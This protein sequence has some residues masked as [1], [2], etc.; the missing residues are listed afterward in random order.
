MA[1]AAAPDTSSLARYQHEQLN[2]LRENLRQAMTTGDTDAVHD[3][4][5]ASRRLHNG[6]EVMEARLGRKRVRRAQR[7]LK[8]VRKAFR[9]VRDLDVL[10]A[11]LGAAPESGSLE[12]NALAE[13]EAI[14]TSRRERAMAVAKRA[15][16]EPKLTKEL[17]SIENLICLL[18]SDAEGEPALVEE[19]LTDM[20]RQRAT[21][22]LQKDP[23]E[24]T[25]NLHETRI[26]VKQMRYCVQ[27]LTDCGALDAAELVEELTA[28]QGLLGHWSDQI[29]AART[30][31]RI[32]GRWRL[33]TGYTAISEKLLAH[34]A[35]RAG[36]SLQ[37]R[38]KVLQRWPALTVVLKKSVPG[39]DGGEAAAE[40]TAAGE[41][42]AESV[43]GG[44]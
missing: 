36:A 37:D 30:F 38:Q 9:E 6:L 16:N 15:G 3:L 17:A 42:S 26:R 12:P 33:L 10:R 19:Q 32:A 25:N 27:L 5:V 2:R 20:L 23:F 28:M 24:E 22:L 7:S 11:S 43:E 34:A 1:H 8:R 40:E 44:G 35:A 41:R 31:S 14:L 29:V 4:R 39:L 13:V 18:A 21:A